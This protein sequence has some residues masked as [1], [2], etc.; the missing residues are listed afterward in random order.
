MDGYPP[1]PARLNPLS[2]NNSMS[3]L[4]Q[5]SETAGRTV[6]KKRSADPKVG[7]SRKAQKMAR[8]TYATWRQD[9]YLDRDEE[10]EAFPVGDDDDIFEDDIDKRYTRTKAQREAYERD[11]SVTER[12]ITEQ[13]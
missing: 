2:G 4:S 13:H 6:T 7:G 9:P 1:P 12:Y 10:G 3:S 11:M 8:S 5:Q